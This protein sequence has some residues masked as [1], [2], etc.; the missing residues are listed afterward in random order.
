MMQYH[1][2]REERIKE[3]TNM[4]LCD[5]FSTCKTCSKKVCPVREDAISRLSEGSG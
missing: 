1:Y 2:W 5:K 3:I 4:N